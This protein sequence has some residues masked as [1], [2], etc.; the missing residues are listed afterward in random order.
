MA[1]TE[2]KF[3]K[4]PKLISREVG[5]VFFIADDVLGKIHS[6]GELGSAIWR[7]LDEPQ[8]REDCIQ[9]FKAAFPDDDDDRIKELVDDAISGLKDKGLVH[10]A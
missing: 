8:S 3:R 5:G 1:N 10:R 2:R 7:L 6:L 4:L 9:V